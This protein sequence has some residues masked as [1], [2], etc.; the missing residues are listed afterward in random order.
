MNTWGFDK[1]TLKLNSDDIHVRVR[2]TF[3]ETIC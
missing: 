2:C 3:T 1:N